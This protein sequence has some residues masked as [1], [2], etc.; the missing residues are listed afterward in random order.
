MC[1]QSQPDG[2]ALA[3]GMALT[4]GTGR[5]RGA[6][7]APCVS[8]HGLVRPAG[9]AFVGRD[10]SVL[11]GPPPDSVCS[12]GMGVHRAEG[13]SVTFELPPVPS[14]LRATCCA[15]RRL[16]RRKVTVTATSASKVLEPLTPQSRPPRLSPTA[17]AA[18][19]APPAPPLVTAQ[20]PLCFERWEGTVTT[21]PSASGVSSPQPS[22]RSHTFLNCDGNVA[23]TLPVAHQ[24]L[25]A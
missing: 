10:A 24:L 25:L 8:D 7:G 21:Q 23:R 9:G 22:T 3:A 5:E 13:S 1:R 20:S 17:K 6:V 11:Y 2:P 4:L 19:M 12:T 18:T 14:R 16:H 15:F